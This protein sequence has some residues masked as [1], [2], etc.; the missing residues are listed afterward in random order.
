M[1]NDAT[2]SLSNNT[3]TIAQ[4]YENCF[5]VHKNISYEAETNSLYIRCDD[6]KSGFCISLIKNGEYQVMLYYF[7][8]QIMSSG[9]Y[10][11]KSLSCKNICDL[12]TCISG[13]TLYDADNN[14]IINEFF[15]TLSQQTN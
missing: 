13:K 12:L 15:Q 7:H 3:L 9:Y 8:E 10:Y 14:G 2:S 1:S 5:Q 6:G 4:L 11:T